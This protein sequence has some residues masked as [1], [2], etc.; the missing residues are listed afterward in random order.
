MENDKLWFVFDM[1]E[2]LASFDGFFTFFELIHPNVL[3][4]ETYMKIV[5]QIAIAE[6]MNSSSFISTIGIFRP[7]LYL[8]FSFLNFLREMGKLG[9][10]A[11]YSNTGFDPHVLFTINVINTWFPGMVCE[12]LSRNSALREQNAVAT[13]SKKKFLKRWDTIEKIFTQ[14]KCGGARP[15]PENTF[16][17]DDLLEHVNIAERIGNNYIHVAPYESGPKQIMFDIVKKIIIEDGRFFDRNNGMIT[18]EFYALLANNR[19]NSQREIDDVLIEKNIDTFINILKEGTIYPI[20]Y[21][22]SQVVAEYQNNWLHGPLNK[23]RS[24]MESY[25]SQKK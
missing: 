18:N 17:Y 9:G 2:T 16:F 1:D 3:G 12:G 19:S 22:P 25:L 21:Q 6:E 14:E 5:Q 23:V 4:T 10:V 13:S 20:D 7:G 8:Y 15:I 24:A 11:I